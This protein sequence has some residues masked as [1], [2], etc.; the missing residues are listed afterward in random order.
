MDTLHDHG[1]LEESSDTFKKLAVVSDHVYPE[2]ANDA[3]LISYIAGYVARKAIL[4][5]AFHD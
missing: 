2:K 4:K 5:I 3:R 1:K